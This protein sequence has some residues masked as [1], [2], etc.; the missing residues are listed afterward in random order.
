MSIAEYRVD[1]N[2]ANAAIRAGTARKPLTPS[3]AV[4]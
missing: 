3:R 2:G 4:C 1:R